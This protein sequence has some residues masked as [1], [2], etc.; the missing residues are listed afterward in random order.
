MN[1]LREQSRTRPI[2]PKE[3]E[4][5]VQIIHKK[6][7]SIQMQL[8][9]RKRRNFSKQASEILNEYFYSHL[10]NPYPSEEAKEE[11]ARKCGIT[12][13]QVSNW[14]GNKRIRYK[15]NIGKAQEEANLYAAKK[16]AAAFAG[17]SPYSMGGAS[18]GT[19][20]PMMSPAPPGGP[21]DMAGYGMGINGSDYGSQPYNDGSMGYDP[22]HQQEW[23][24]EEE[25]KNEKVK[26]IESNELD[27]SWIEFIGL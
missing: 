3:I 23:L 26:K 21:Q 2:T 7:S 1:L 13:S 4:R 20:T 15:K 16:A 22:M 14:F 11:L 17:A 25:W 6:F 24:N 18:Q 8:K 19:P 5:M 10:S 9:Q 12:V 27:L